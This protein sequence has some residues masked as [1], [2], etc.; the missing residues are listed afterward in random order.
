M[1]KTELE[2]EM[3]IVSE[4]LED[5][6]NDIFYKR[7][8]EHGIVYGDLEP[9]LYL[10]IDEKAEQLSRAIV[11]GIAFQMVWCANADSE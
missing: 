7:Q 1:N 10:D 8:T 4:M 11:E 9:L 3:T 5:A 6:I 2:K